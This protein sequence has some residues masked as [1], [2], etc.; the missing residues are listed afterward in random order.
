MILHQDTQELS[1]LGDI[2]QI[3]TGLAVFVLVH[4]FGRCK[5]HQFRAI[6]IR[7]SIATFATPPRN[8][9]WLG[10]RGR[11]HCKSLELFS[12]WIPMY[13][14]VLPMQAVGGDRLRRMK[15]VSCQFHLHVLGVGAWTSAHLAK[16]C[17]DI[18]FAK[19][20]FAK[21]MR[22]DGSEEEQLKIGVVVVEATF[23]P[24]PPHCDFTNYFW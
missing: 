19:T 13:M 4:C 15:F 3:W 24:A 14:I 7:F 11:P 20:L 8:S 21:T 18:D 17:S 10:W 22:I 9:G 23:H 5:P 12:E 1:A 2:S 6:A 16:L